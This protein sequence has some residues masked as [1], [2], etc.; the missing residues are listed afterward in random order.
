[1]SPSPAPG[2]MRPAQ[3]GPP[4]SAPRQSRPGP[5][6]GVTRVGHAD[7]AGQAPTEAGTRRGYAGRPSGTAWQAPAES[8]THSW[9]PSGTTRQ[10][11][12]E[13]GT[14]AGLP[15]D[16][17]RQA[18]GEGATSAGPAPGAG[19][20]GPVGWQPRTTPAPGVQPVPH[21][22]VV[23]Q[24]PG[25]PDGWQPDGGTDHRL[26]VPVERPEKRT[27]WRP[28]AL[29][30]VLLAGIVVAAG[31]VVATLPRGGDGNKA[32]APAPTTSAAVPTAPPTSAR[33]SASAVSGAPI[34]VKLRDNRDSVSLTWGYPK[35]SEG[36]VLISGG[37]SG[38]EQRAFQQ[39]P[40]GTTDYVV[41]GLNASTDYCFTV[42]V[43]YT[44]DRVAASKPVCTKRK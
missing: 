19:R 10:E 40:A 3:A 22:D 36:P 5:A 23:R 4:Q 6:D 39:L 20:A 15:S 12:A 25:R 13:D 33:A 42:A 31:V 7:P 9:P 2:S 32:A 26:P 30:A 27:S 43:V 14:P 37:R 28:L 24:R 41:Y 29:V 44:V 17:A 38:Q 16:I 11:P 8:G 21:P 34:N 18:P 35:G 1:V